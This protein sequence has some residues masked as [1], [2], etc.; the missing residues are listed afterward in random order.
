MRKARTVSSM[1]S[2]GGIILILSGK[3]RLVLCCNLSRSLAINSSSPH[4]SS[5]PL[6]FANV[7]VI[8][9]FLSTPLKASPQLPC[10]RQ[11]I[12]ASG[13][14]NPISSNPSSLQTRAR[15]LPR[16]PTN[17]FPRPP[18]HRKPNQLR[19][20][21]RQPDL[22]ALCSLLTLPMSHYRPLPAIVVAQHPRPLLGVSSVSQCRL[23]P[24]FMIT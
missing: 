16:S 20:S 13:A 17:P 14:A 5:N 11:P 19:L 9:P 21:H 1:A 4:S 15:A 3:N 12:L 23:S 10:H 6:L 18:Y 22:L 7:P 24:H 2:R 8:S